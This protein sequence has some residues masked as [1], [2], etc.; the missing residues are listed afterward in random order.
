MRATC[1]DFMQTLSHE[2]SRFKLTLLLPLKMM[3]NVFKYHF[4]FNYWRPWRAAKQEIF[5]EIK[6]IKNNNNKKETN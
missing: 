5:A 6:K 1:G 2:I 3:N 4:L